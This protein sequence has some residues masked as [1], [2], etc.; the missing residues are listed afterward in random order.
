MDAVA[1]LQQAA[2]EFDREKT[3]AA[4]TELVAAVRRGGPWPDRRALQRALTALRDNRWFDLLESTI[5]AMIHAGDTTPVVRRLY[6]QALIDSGAIAAAI[7][8]LERLDHD[9]GGNA[10][11]QA[12]V[13]GLIGR[14]WKQAY[15][16]SK[17]LTRA[18]A[19]T[20]LANA[21]EA[22]YG[23]Y[24]ERTFAWHGI[25]TVALLTR[26]AADGIRLS[27]FPTRRELAQEIFEQVQDSSAP[28]DYAT[29]AEACVALRRWDEALRWLDKYVRHPSTS[30]FAI[31]GTLRQL[32]DVWGLST[33]GEGATLVQMLRAAMLKKPG[34][35]HTPGE[36]TAPVPKGADSVLQAVLGDDRYVSLEWYRRGLDRSRAVARIGLQQSQGLGTG[37]LVRG[38]DV[39]FPRRQQVLVTNYHV[40]PGLVP[41]HRAVVTFQALDSATKTYG[42]TRVLWSSPVEKLDCAIV[43]LD[44]DVEDVEPY[45]I[46]AGVPTPAGKP[47]VYVIGHPMG[48]T[49][50]FSISDNLLIDY[51]DPKIQYRAPT[52]PGSSGSPVF[53]AN[54]DLLALHH[55]GHQEQMPKL[56]GTGMHAANEGL[57][58]AAI[59]KRC[60][61][62]VKKK[63]K[64]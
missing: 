18:R 33:E 31:Q 58:F 28:W 32:T 10:D 6:A 12:E 9:C 25:N 35:R 16:D 60:A 59:A 54:W 64:R 8:F 11:E 51:V 41:H 15:L 3:Q 30:A 44:D 50:S 61:A 2:E 56:D 52:N 26:G 42:I 5:D 22:Y 27:G 13:R 20:L 29:A 19:K 53:D 49:L 36:S 24:R 34:G 43:L 37:F 40:I 45:P 1:K 63:K 17:G 4:A 57:S 7:A 39:G 38:R 46:C 62:D 55:A 21:T 14:A 47:R 23:V 48:G